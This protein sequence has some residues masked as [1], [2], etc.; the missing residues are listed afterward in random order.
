MVEPVLCGRLEAA[1]MLGLGAT[2]T[3]ELISCGVLETVRIG[4]RRLVKIKSVR[5]L[6]GDIEPPSTALAAEFLPES[7]R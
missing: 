3:D 5:R 6:A 1:K 2:K 4:A 7:I